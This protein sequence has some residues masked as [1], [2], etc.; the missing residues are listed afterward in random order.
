MPTYT[1]KCPSCS[2]RF[3]KSLKV[4]E[5]H[6]IP[7]PSCGVAVN[8]LPPSSVGMKMAEPTKIPKDIDKAVG[9]DAEKKWMD[10]EEKKKVKEKLRKESG[11]EKLSVDFDRNY[12]P[13]AMNVD[14]QQVSGTEATKYRKEM[15]NDYL[16]IKK[17]PDTIKNVPTKEDLSK[18]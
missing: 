10:Y 4:N 18:P 14:G 16:T 8:K 15:L 1:F 12:Q 7:C 13:F 2:L 5:D 6:G 3:E 11:S 17:D 9:K